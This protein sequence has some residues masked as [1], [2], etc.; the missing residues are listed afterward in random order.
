[1]GYWSQVL[2]TAAPLLLADALA[3]GGSVA[4]AS[5]LDKHGRHAER[6]LCYTHIDVAG[7][8]TEGTDWQ[9]GRP[10]GARPGRLLRNRLARG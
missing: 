1:M 3:V 4:I 5:G 2:L 10:T 6:P 9:H 8:A 7:S